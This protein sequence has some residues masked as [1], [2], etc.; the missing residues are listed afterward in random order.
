MAEYERQLQAN[1]KL[2]NDE[3]FVAKMIEESLRGS[4]MSMVDDE[5]Q[6]NMDREE[7]PMKHVPTPCS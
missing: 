4:K 2:R 5:T 3:D 7:K 1:P 6:A